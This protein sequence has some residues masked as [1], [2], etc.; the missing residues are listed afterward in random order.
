MYYAFEHSGS[1]WNLEVL[2]FEERGKPLGAEKE[3][4]NLAHIWPELRIEP[5]PHRWE[6]SALTTAPALLPSLAE[7]MT[8]KIRPHKE[9]PVKNW[10]LNTILKQFNRNK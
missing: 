7:S 10:I 5:G 9:S 4:T 2:V 8:I 1:N 3:P 6:A